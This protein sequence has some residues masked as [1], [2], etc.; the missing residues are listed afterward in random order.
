[1]ALSPTR[2]LPIES[3]TVI[4]DA[5]LAQLPEE[6]A[7]AVIVVKPERPLPSS[8]ANSRAGTSTNQYDPG[9]MYLLE[10]AAILTLR[11]SQ[12]IQTLGEG[13]LA[14]LQG[15]IRDAQNLHSLALSRVTTYLL[16]LLRLSHVCPKFSKSLPMY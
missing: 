5:L 16:N 4:V 11:D 13:L 15:F 7:P 9:M 3:V 14:S 6:S 10:L 12:T 8:R 2:S 1:M